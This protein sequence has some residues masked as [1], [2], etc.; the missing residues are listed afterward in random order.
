MCSSA[1][2]IGLVIYA[3]MYIRLR[4]TIPALARAT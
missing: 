4:K 1:A 2:L 3:V